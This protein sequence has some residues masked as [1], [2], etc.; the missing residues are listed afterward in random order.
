[1]SVDEAIQRELEQGCVT[2]FSADPIMSDT[3]GNEVHCLFCSCCVE[4]CQCGTPLHGEEEGTC[5]N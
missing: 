2:E 3:C 5:G 1:M 4:H